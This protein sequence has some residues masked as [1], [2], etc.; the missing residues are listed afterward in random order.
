MYG[1]A[2]VYRSCIVAGFLVSVLPGHLHAQ[3]NFIYLN[4][5]L[6]KEVA[7][8][9]TVSG[10]SAAAN[11][12]LVSIPGSPFLTGGVGKGGSFIALNRIASC[13]AGNFLYAA[14][15]TSGDISGFSI[16]QSTGALSSVPG[17]PFHVAG[18]GVVGSCCA[19]DMSL[20]CMPNGRFLIVAIANLVT[21]FTIASNGALTPQSSV[22]IFGGPDGIK[23]SPDNKFLA[24][25]A[26]LGRVDM[27]TIASDGALTRAPGSPFRPVL[28]GGSPP[29]LIAGVDINCAGNLLFAGEATPDG[30]IVDVFDISSDGVL[31][32]I[33]GSRFSPGV[34]AGANSNVVLL[35]SDDKFLFVSNQGSSSVT[36]FAVG[37]DGGLVPVPGSPF[38]VPDAPSV[39]SPGGMALD[40]SGEHLY[41]VDEFNGVYGYHIEA[42][43]ALTLVPDSPFGRT[44]HGSRSIA[45]FPG[46]ACEIAVAVDVKPGSAENPVNPKSRGVIPVAILSTSAF[47]ASTVDSSS[48]RLGPNQASPTQAGGQLED[49]NGD[50]KPDLV[51][52]FR[53]QDSGIQCGD[54]SVSI[55]GRTVSGVPIKGSD[56]ITTVGC[57]TAKGEQN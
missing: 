7:V 2:T 6:Q 14:N 11:G 41:V 3:P 55:T 22:E 21:V 38:A 31:T 8:E 10:F 42:G 34:G 26:P 18:A 46:K 33:P 45:A 52:H 23:I 12:A 4:D 36:V 17:S 48:V 43:G 50:G 57:K 40:R 29:G 53:V 16:D 19:F 13:N 20:A 35:S 27:F 54:T 32:P 49:V 1:L 25:V 5:N 51:L 37:N 47:A 24:V 15:A 28:Y 39:S 56:S 30:T 44:E 9:N